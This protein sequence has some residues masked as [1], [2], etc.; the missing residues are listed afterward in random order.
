MLVLHGVGIERALGFV[1]HED[2]L[3]RDESGLRR[4]SADIVLH[5]A[6]EGLAVTAALRSSYWRTST[7]GPLPLR[8]LQ[9]RVPTGNRH[10]QALSIPIEREPH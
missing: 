7:S 1:E 9:T 8:P 3:G 4:V 6:H 10:R 5:A 2:V